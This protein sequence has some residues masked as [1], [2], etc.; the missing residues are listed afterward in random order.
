VHRLNESEK[1]RRGL[2]DVPLS[3][4]I[5]EVKARALLGG[6]APALAR[7]AKDARLDLDKH[8]KL[9]DE[10]GQELSVDAS[11]EVLR[12]GSHD[13][14]EAIQLITRSVPARVTESD[15]A[16]VDVTKVVS[17][18]ETTF[19]LFGSGAGR[20]INIKNAASRIDG[21]ILLPGAIFSFNDAV[22]P[23]TKDRGFVLAP[24]I[25]GDEMADGYGGG[26]CQAS[27][28]LHAAALFG[29]LEIID[30][31]AHSRPSSYTQMGLDATVSFPL[32]DLKL[33]NTLPFPV[34]IHAYP[35]KPTAIRVE[36]LGGNPV[37]KVDYLFAVNAT[38]DFVRRVTVKANLR[39]GQ[40]IRRQKGT[41]GYEVSSFV[42]IHYFDGRED[43]RRWFSG[44]RP[45]P[46]V[47][48]VPPGFDTG[49]LPPLPDHAKGVEGSAFAGQAVAAAPGDVGG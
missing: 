49:E 12:A 42:K 3:W 39:P 20:A 29:A 34:M 38:E 16:S 35:P 2:V 41:R 47:F 11:L 44:Y 43:E 45:S 8:L 21:T 9:P 25:Q 23:R 4:S 10:P 40:R 24:E 33:R 48:W 37:A 26:T 27:S 28:T 15:L 32:A 30:R 13:D 46:E 18:Y 7:A 5:D 6:Y 22:G 31:Q 19:S 14:D 1:A 17:S 36:I